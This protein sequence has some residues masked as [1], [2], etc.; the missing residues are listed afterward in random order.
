M[1]LI[2]SGT[3]FPFEFQRLQFPIK[4]SFAITI[5][6][7]Q[8]QTL[9]FVYLWLGNESVFTHGQLDV[10]LSRVNDSKNIFIALDQPEGMTRNVVYKEIFQ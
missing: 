1:P 9:D 7:A 10:A 8:G 3:N 6:K 5:S 4:P 2:P